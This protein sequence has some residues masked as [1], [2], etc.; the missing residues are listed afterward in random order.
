MKVKLL[1]L[2]P[3]FLSIQNEWHYNLEEAKNIA[4]KEHKYILLN[5]SGSDWCGPCIRMRKEIFESAVFKEMADSEL[6]LV[7]ADFPRNKKNQPSAAQQKMNDEMADKYNSQGKF[8]YTL[9][10]DPNGKVLQTWEGFPEESVESFTV[11]IRNA[12]YTVRQ[13]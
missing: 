1:L 5:F 7:N 4:Q 3:L 10:L 6:I 13:K 8:P 2:L 12:M 9:L 11:D